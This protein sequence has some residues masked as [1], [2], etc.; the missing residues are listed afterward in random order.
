MTTE[1]LVT[2]V[3]PAIATANLFLF[4]MAT[5]DASM[6]AWFG[7]DGPGLGELKETAHRNVHAKNNQE[8]SA[9]KAHVCSDLENTAKSLHLKDQ[10]I[11]HKL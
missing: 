9:D 11:T 8:G 6:S 3:M 7:K 4:Q 2:H 5:L 1:T 10:K